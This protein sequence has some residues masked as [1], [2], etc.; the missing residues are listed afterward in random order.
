MPAE[1]EVKEV[2][3]AAFPGMGCWEKLPHGEQ[4]MQ[5][6]EGQDLGGKTGMKH[7]RIL[8]AVP[9]RWKGWTRSLWDPIPVQE[10]CDSK[11]M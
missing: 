11:S 8:G 6:R 10:F 7:G 3:G 5:E 9:C 4:S 1:N 2:K